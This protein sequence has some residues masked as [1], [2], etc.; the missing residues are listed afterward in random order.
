M[1]HAII[2]K[3]FANCALNL[4]LWFL[5]KQGLLFVSFFPGEVDDRNGL[6]ISFLVDRQDPLHL[7][8]ATTH[9]P[10]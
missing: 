10:F 4:G 8:P 1:D 9:H 7:Q 6:L 5:V 2:Q 3:R